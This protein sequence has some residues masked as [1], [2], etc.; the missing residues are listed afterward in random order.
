MSPGGAAVSSLVSQRKG[1]LGKPQVSCCCPLLPWLQVF[2]GPLE[3]RRCMP[4]GWKKREK[5]EVQVCSREGEPLWFLWREGLK[6]W[7]LPWLVWLSGLSTGCKPKCC[8]FDSQ[9]R[10]HAWVAG[11]V[12]SGGH[13][14]GNHT[15]I[16]LSLSPPFP[17]F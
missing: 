16:V 1:G 2:W 12:P 5:G 8:R 13:M 7:K 3:F 14:R 6:G 4:V 15:L 11:Q 9:F 10:A 17:S